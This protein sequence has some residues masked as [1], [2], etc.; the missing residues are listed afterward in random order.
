M[1]IPMRPR[2]PILI[3]DI[4]TAPDIALAYDNYSPKLD[5]EVSEATAWNDL[6]IVEAIRAQKNVNFLPTIFHTVV[7]ICAVFVNPETFT[8]LDGFKKTIPTPTSGEELRKGERALLKSFWEFS[9]KYRDQARVWYDASQSDLRLTD[10]QRRKIRMLPVTFCGYNISGFDLPVIEQRSLKHL[11]TCPIPEYAA[12]DG[13]DSYRYKFGSDRVFDLC[14]FVSNHQQQT[15]TGL[16]NLARSMGLSGKMEGMHGSKVAE[17]YFVH[18]EWQK[19]EEYCAVDVLITYGVFLG[20]QKFRGIIDAESFREC[21]ASFRNFLMQD[22]KPPS[23]RALA[24][25]SEAFFN[26]KEE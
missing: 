21:Q 17:H 4:E 7:S 23:Y 20:I 9:L 11:L 15:R 13:I 26:F 16:D 19:I 8:L 1:L 2:A 22:N 3:F 25:G 5:F 10:Q 18:G 14:S 6:R 12:E 24:E